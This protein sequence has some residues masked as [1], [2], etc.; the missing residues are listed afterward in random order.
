MNRL[1]LVALSFAPVAAACASQPRSQPATAASASAPAAAAA[2]HAAPAHA[3]LTPAG[4]AGS[5]AEF[6]APAGRADTQRYE[7]WPDGRFEWHAARAS[8]AK[9]GRRSGHWALQSTPE[10]DALLL[11][12][13][14]EEERFGC[15][16]SAACRV[17]HDPPLQERLP[18]GECPPNDEARKLDASYRCI[19]INGQ[20]F[21]H[22]D[23]EHDREQPAAAP[24]PPAAPG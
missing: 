21:W 9:V 1:L 23:R 22:H 20:A 15:E 10:G 11:Q 8:N 3:A 16:G 4:L 14:V 19:A 7:L 6:W 5:W 2:A 17:S 24:A 13:Q 12:V 18:L